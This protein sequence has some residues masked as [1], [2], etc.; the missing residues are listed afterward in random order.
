MHQLSAH[1]VA[2]F[3]E[4]DRQFTAAQGREHGMPIVQP[5]HERFPQLTLFLI[6]CCGLG[7]KGGM[8][9]PQQLALPAHR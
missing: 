9:D 5:C 1:P 7:V 3:L 8:A 6:W 2:F 4:L